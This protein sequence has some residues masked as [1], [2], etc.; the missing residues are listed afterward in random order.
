MQPYTAESPAPLLSRGGFGKTPWF[1]GANDRSKTYPV[2]ITGR[3]PSCKIRVSGFLFANASFSGG[4]LERQ[5]IQDNDVRVG[6][7]LNVRG[8]W[9]EG[10]RI[11][12][13]WDEPMK[14]D[15]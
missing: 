15:V 13:A 5:P 8:G 9:L 7:M 2:G 10:M 1:D 3:S 6:D 14:V 4:H 12:A 11:G